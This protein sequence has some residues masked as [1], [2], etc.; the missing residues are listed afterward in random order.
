MDEQQ[1]ISCSSNQPTRTIPHLFHIFCAD[2]HDHEYSERQ[3]LA[4]VQEQLIAQLIHLLTIFNATNSPQILP[5]NL[6]IS[7]STIP[8]A[9]RG[10]F[11]R[12]EIP[13]G[14]LVGLYPGVVFSPDDIAVASQLVFEDNHYLISRLFDCLSSP[15]TRRLTH[16]RPRA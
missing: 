15:L 13:A 10:L 6:K 5:Y 2:L 4:V 12:Q 14:S 16:Y 8:G 7:P 11:A 3:M 9:E 1:A